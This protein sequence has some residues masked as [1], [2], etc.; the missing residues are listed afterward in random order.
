MHCA[1]TTQ[2]NKT[3]HRDR[4][5]RLTA[6]CPSHKN[7]NCKTLHFANADAAAAADANADAGGS[8]TALPGLHP[9]ELKSACLLSKATQFWLG[10]SC[11]L[12]SVYCYRRT[13]SKMP[14]CVYVIAHETAGSVDS[15]GRHHGK[16]I[17]QREHD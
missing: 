6:P 2:A 15:R 3:C 9:G 11:Y 12:F 1:V 4:I 13:W 8:T 5:A 16:E 10:C 7:L 17:R 14:F